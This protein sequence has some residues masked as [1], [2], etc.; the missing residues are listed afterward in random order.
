MTSRFVLKFTLP[1]LRIARS[2]F[3]V[4][5]SV[6]FLIVVLL[7]ASTVDLPLAAKFGDVSLSAILTSGIAAA[8]WLL[9]MIQIRFPLRSLI[10]VLAGAGF[11]L[12]LLI[13]AG[14]NFP[15]SQGMQNLVVL[16]GFIGLIL[17]SMRISLRHP[18]FSDTIARCIGVGLVVAV[19]L[20]T[21]AKLNQ[22]FGTDFVLSIQGQRLLPLYALIPLSWSLSRWKRGSKAHLLVAVSIML[23]ILIDLSRM[24]LIVGFVLFVLAQLHSSRRIP[25]LRLAFWGVVV[26]AGVWLLITTYEPLR[27]RF[28]EADT[29]L[30]IGNVAI[31]STGRTRIWIAVLES[32]KNSLYIGHGAGSAAQISYAVGRL[33]HPHN[34]YLRLLH[35]YGAIGLVLWLLFIVANLVTIWRLWRR[36]AH[37]RTAESTLHQTA[38]LALLGIS[39]TMLSDNTLAYSFVMFP[40]A[41]LVGASIGR[42]AD[43]AALPSPDAD[44]AQLAVR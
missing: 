41:I 3:R 9:W 40:L 21:T 42:S 18:D 20:F 28:F 19:F 23:M 44:A 13:A 29:S 22:W 32:V 35:D 14:V 11:L 38:F 24:A 26:A 4:E 37:L 7:V 43:H 2:H 16:F 30:V 12:W 1:R 15:T 34:D 10:V 31:N 6:A 33:D 17:L 25:W 39:I 36:T 27:A 5:L 8:A